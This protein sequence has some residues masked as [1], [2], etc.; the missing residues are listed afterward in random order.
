MSSLLRGNFSEFFELQKYD[1][2]QIVLFRQI[3]VIVAL[4]AHV[5]LFNI[6]ISG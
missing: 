1:N 5:C 6:S 3:A 2:L 4:F